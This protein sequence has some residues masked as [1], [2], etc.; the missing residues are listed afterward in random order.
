[1]PGYLVRK[2]AV[3]EQ[4][5]TQID[6]PVRQRLRHYVALND[7]TVADVVNLALD[8][9]LPSLTEL[10]SRIAEA[11]PQATQGWPLPVKETP[12]PGPSPL[13]KVNT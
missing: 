12:A 13:R 3:R 2:V 7:Q 5:S 1:M 11:A 10:A 6:T 8:G 9:F 4:M